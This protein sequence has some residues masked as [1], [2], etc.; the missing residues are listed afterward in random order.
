MTRSL[1]IT[2]KVATPFGNIFV[3]VDCAP[4]GTVQSVGFSQ[5]GKNENTTVGDALD[6]LQRTVNLMIEQ[7][8]G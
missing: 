1:A 5:P 4:D 2:E 6:A 8:R 3:H 7:V